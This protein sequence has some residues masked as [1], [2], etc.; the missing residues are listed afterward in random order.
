MMMLGGYSSITL[1]SAYYTQNEDAEWNR[2][3]WGL[4]Y[5]GL[6]LYSNFSGVATLGLGT[7]ALNSNGV[8]LTRQKRYSVSP[9]IVGLLT[10]DIIDRGFIVRARIFSMS[11][12]NTTTNT[13][14]VNL[15]LDDGS[16]SREIEL[17]ITPTDIKL[18]DIEGS[19]DVFSLTGLS[20]DHVDI[21]IAMAGRNCTVYYRDVD[22]IS[23]KRTWTTAG[24]TTSLTVGA[25]VSAET[26]VRWGNL[27]YASGTLETVWTEIVGARGFEIGEQI[28]SFSSPSD[29]FQRA[30]PPTGQYAY[31]ADNVRISST[32]GATYEGDSFS[33]EPTS[34]YKIENVFYSISPTRRVTWRSASVVSGNVP[35]QFIALK[36]DPDTS[37]HRDESLPNDIVGIHLSNINFVDAKL[38]YY[39]SA[40]WTVLDTFKTSISSE[41]LVEGRTVRGANTAPNQPYFLSLIHI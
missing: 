31:V 22:S 16:S 17:R 11:G 15:R 6:D 39:S 23:N 13:R 2:L 35:E 5:P 8:A 29:L 38:E 18:R 12:G 26:R 10:S 28:T 1:P 19:L 4:T 37:I 25:T 40:S 24:S 33:I 30:Y 14:G 36:L 20:L 41:C 7:E 32:D 27:D 9:S 3:S 21:M 34:N